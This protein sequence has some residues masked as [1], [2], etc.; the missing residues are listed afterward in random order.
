M[1]F[2]GGVALQA[3]A[4][5]KYTTAAADLQVG[6][7]YILQNQRPNYN[8]WLTENTTTNK[9]EATS[10]T[11]PKSQSV[12]NQM[13]VVTK[14]SGRSYTLRN[15]ATGRYIDG[16]DRQ[17]E[18]W[19]TTDTKTSQFAYQIEGKEHI[20]AFCV[21]DKAN[22]NALHLGTQEGIVSWN[23]TEI[24][25]QWLVKQ[26]TITDSETSADVT[27]ARVMA[28]LEKFGKPGL[29]DG[30]YYRIVGLGSG[31]AVYVDYGD[32]SK[33]K[34]GPKADDYT[35]YFKAVQQVVSGNPKAGKFAL[36]SVYTHKFISISAGNSENFKA[37]TT[38]KSYFTI[39]QDN[40]YKYDYIYTI[41]GSSTSWN[42]YSGGSEVKG[43]TG[44][45]DNS[46][47]TFEEVKVT[48]EEWENALKQ[49]N[50]YAT[51]AKITAKQKSLLYSL[52]TDK[53]CFEFNDDIK[54]LSDE[55]FADSISTLPARVQEFIL[56]QRN[57]T[58][59]S[60]PSGRNWEKEFRMRS[61]EVSSDP[62]QS[63]WNITKV[64]YQYTHIDKPMGIE[65][66]PH[67]VLMLM[68]E[69]LPANCTFKLEAVEGDGN[70]GTQYD[71]TA[72]LNVISVPTRSTLYIVYYI[73][74]TGTG[75]QYELATYSDIKV[76][77]EGG[78]VNGYLDLCH[79]AKG[80]GNK[81]WHDMV[82]DGL[83]KRGYR[84]NIKTNT[85][86][87]HI[88]SSR[89][90]P[91]SHKDIDIELS[92]R[93]Y[94]EILQHEHAA[95][96]LN[97]W[98]APYAP[99]DKYIPNL[100][101]IFNNRWASHDI[102]SGLYASSYGGYYGHE[103]MNVIFDPEDMRRDGQLWLFA[104]EHGHNNQ[105]LINMVN[106]TEVSNNLLACI[107]NNRR[108]FYGSRNG[109][110]ESVANSYA[111]DT[112]VPDYDL[113]DRMQ[114]YNKLYLY[115]HRAGHEKEFYPLLFKKFRTETALNHRQNVTIP[116][117]EDYLLFAINSC[118]IMKQDLSPL[119]EAYGYFKPSS[120]CTA[121]HDES[122]DNTKGHY[123]GDYGNY[124]LKSDAAMIAR[125]RAAMA[126]CGPKNYGIV[127]IE[128]RITRDQAEYEGAEKGVLHESRGDSGTKFGGEKMGE[129]GAGQVGQWWQY[130][131][132]AEVSRAVG[133]TCSYTTST[134]T[135]KVTPAETWKYENYTDNDRKTRKVT[136][137]EWLANSGAV[138]FLVYD[139]NDVLVYY[140]SFMNF[141]LPT[142][143][144]SKA[145]FNASKLT[146]YVA[147][148]D[149][150]REKMYANGA[151]TGATTG[152]NVEGGIVT[153]I[154]SVTTVAPSANAIYD[155]SG[156]RHS[157]LR[158]GLNIIGGTKVIIK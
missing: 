52:Y 146:V 79:T 102:T 142:S 70:A 25:S 136:K 154:D 48:D 15:L 151:S 16:I 119:F 86:I 68:V 55:K 134:K 23:G 59:E 135:F 38:S 152:V 155:L 64:G 87:L 111:N 95:M 21:Q 58:W 131:P 97:E 118:K 120:I 30:K 7:L 145:G 8:F 37:S 36:Q 14:N 41:Q 105:S 93:K 109:S 13:W 144:T 45:D 11:E 44:I 141:S 46:R 99:T 117:E 26:V 114:L 82:T 80:E 138:G 49:Y 28:Q 24:A 104:H 10:A 94:D 139:E 92:A 150:S 132:S 101:K 43:W 113:W 137:A 127:F 91:D 6:G 108:G 77:I 73:N 130:K 61:Y 157:A 89:L 9:L 121:T 54:A 18:N 149:G 35:Q 143:V 39:A 124:Y 90:K 98:E 33:L 158:K 125:A 34:F 42:K 153:G 60:F 140:S 112:Y 1:F 62:T 27:A 78:V 5:D 69:K 88:R 17:H 81:N 84:L 148:A 122:Q 56:K 66:R 3:S 2:V 110:N 57:N 75:K 107:A 106:C 71:L 123:S 53:S 100:T 50:D 147:N 96:G 156:R 29:E 76:R 19:Y 12:W 65:A 116:A 85:T 40:A 72:G 22:A 47:F 31:Q 32:Q 115:A 133:Y 20:Y 67:D 103:S 83:L 4:A 63:C 126:E 129:N 74:G 128:D 51:L